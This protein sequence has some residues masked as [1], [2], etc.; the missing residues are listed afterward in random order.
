MGR[1]LGEFLGGLHAN[2]VY[3]LYDREGLPVGSQPDI[4]SPV[5]GT[6]GYHIRSGKHDVTDYDWQQYLNFADLHLGGESV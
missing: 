6:I 2:A 4:E 1:P 3:Q 5:M